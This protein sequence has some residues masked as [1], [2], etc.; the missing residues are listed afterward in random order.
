M[1]SSAGIMQPYFLPYIGY[2]QL[3]GQVG[4][5]VIYD[6][7][8]YTKKGW[9]NRNRILLEGRPA[10][11][12]LPLKNG[13]DHLEIGQRQIADSFRASV[14]LNK[15]S[16]A[17]RKAPFYEE[18]YGLLKS[19]LDFPGCNLFDFLRNSIAATC[20]HLGLGTRIVSS[21]E[22]V[23]GSHLRGQDRVI[24]L[25]Q[26][27]G[28]STYLNPIGGKELYSSS[29]FEQAGIQLRFLKSNLSPYTQCGQAFVEALSII[30]VLC[31]NGRQ[32][33]ASL[34]GRDFRIES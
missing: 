8:K 21:S 15:I 1:S 27:L 25:C 24:A 34:V 14:I 32:V 20:L 12:T 6:N 18:T 11:I 4:T 7:I 13:P 28:A 3:I 10:T 26:A 22:I 19:I 9:I 17:Y 16:A 30:D 2:F 33:T 31:F 5:F 23:T 29:V